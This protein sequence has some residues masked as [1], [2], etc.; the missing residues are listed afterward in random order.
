MIG[1]N[2]KAM[3]GTQMALLAHQ[4]KCNLNDRLQQ[5]LPQ[6]S[7]RDPW[8]ASH[9]T[10]T[11]ILCHRMGMETFQG[12]FTWWGSNL[13][14][15]QSYAKF[16]RLKPVYDYR[17]T[18]G[19]TNMGFTLAGDVIAKLSGR[20]WHEN[21]A[22]VLFEPLGMRNS[23]TRIDT[24][25]TLPAGLAMPHTVVEGKLIS[26]PI[27]PIDNLAPC[28]SVWSTAEDMSHWAMMLLDSGRW[29]GKQVLPWEV[30]A[31]TRTPVSISGRVDDARRKS[32]YDLYG[33]GWGLQDIYGREMVAH[34]GGVNGFVSSVTLFPEEKLGIVV[35]TNTDANNLFQNLKW[36]LIDLYFGQ[37]YENVSARNFGRFSEYEKMRWNYINAQRDS[38]AAGVESDLALKAFAG[39]YTNEVYG[40]VTLQV[41]G[42]GLEMSFENHPHMTAALGRLTR[43]RFLTTYSDP[44]FGIVVTQFRTKGKKVTGLEL[45]CADFV[46]FTPYEFVKK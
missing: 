1:S 2:T 37:P 39:T 9:V 45:R 28:G 29:Q 36:Q 42:N 19:Y 18:W 41:K 20:S 43:D 23:L 7:M 38:V 44:T 26:I 35:L 30:I 15:A 13:T 27:E 10:L 3:T 6:F 16:A 46:E 33:L 32:H 24:A 11:D 8:V 31:T 40:K 25:S 14:D 17:T 34:T 4:G 5:H 12:D 21:T 22:A